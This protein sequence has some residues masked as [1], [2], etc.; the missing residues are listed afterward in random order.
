M[1]EIFSTNLYYFDNHCIVTANGEVVG[2][3]GVDGKSHLAGSEQVFGMI[4]ARF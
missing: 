2:D 4:G 3:V 1:M